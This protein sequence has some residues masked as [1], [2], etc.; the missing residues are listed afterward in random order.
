[1]PLTNDDTGGASI[2]LAQTSPTFSSC[3]A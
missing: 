1:V 3:N 2:C